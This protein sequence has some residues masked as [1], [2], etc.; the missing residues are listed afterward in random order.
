MANGK[1]NGRNSD[2]VKSEQRATRRRNR[3]S[4]D[5]AEWG[6]AN[7]EAILTLISAVAKHGFAIRFGYTRD[8]GAF[9]IGIV[10]DGEPFTEYCRPNED[11]DQFVAGF[12][13]DYRDGSRPAHTT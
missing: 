4:S 13:E 8:G 3:G 6:D 2:V 12:I 9:A 5:A 7:A 11:I 10:G 1:A